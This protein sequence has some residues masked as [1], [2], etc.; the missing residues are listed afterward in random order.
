ML[1]VCVSSLGNTPPRP[2]AR[3]AGLAQAALCATEDCGS[4]ESALR[5][6]MQQPLSFS[7]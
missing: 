6:Y 2:Q 1:S 3:L 5:H 7:G 4:V